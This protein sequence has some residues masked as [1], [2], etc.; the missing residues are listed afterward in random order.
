[1]FLDLKRCEKDQ[2]RKKEKKIAIKPIF[3]VKIMHFLYL[4]CREEK[5]WKK[6][7]KTPIFKTKIT[8]FH[9]ISITKT[10]KKEKKK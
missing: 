4:E 6:M 7:A 9:Q 5:K 8:D 10:L 1:M 3:R 2:Q